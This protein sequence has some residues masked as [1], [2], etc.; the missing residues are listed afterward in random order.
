MA[1]LDVQDVARAGLNPAFVAAAAGGDE[2][3][4][5][6]GLFVVV[7]NGSAAEVTVTLN[8]QE[9]C[10]QGFDHDETVAV[11]AGGERW[12][13]EFSDRFKSSGGNVAWTYSDVTSV[14]VG[15]FA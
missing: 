10:N 13:G 11:P 12:I 14:T 15:A 3:P 4:L 2:A 7:K 1:V 9:A 5:V 6:A 8:S